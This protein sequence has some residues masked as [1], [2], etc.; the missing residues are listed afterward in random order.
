MLRIDQR[1]EGNTIVIRAEGGVAGPWVAEL[2]RA[3]APLNGS[4][5]DVALDLSAVGYVDSSGEQLLRE[6][7]SRGMRIRERSGFVTALFEADTATPSDR[8]LAWAILSGSEAAFLSL[9]SRCHEPM[10]AV[11][12]CFVASEATARKLVHQAW[13]EL[14]SSLKTW[15]GR[16]PLDSWAVCVAARRA[17]AHAVRGATEAVAARADE[18][19]PGVS[20]EHLHPRDQISAADDCFREPPDAWRTDR[21]EL[22]EALD[23]T[24]K[25][26]DA[27]PPMQRAVMTMRDVAGCGADETGSAL[28]I[29]QAE[30]RVLLHRARSSVHAAIDAH[31][32]TAA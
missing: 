31:F 7:V 18:A 8:E 15:N 20:P 24:R 28:N 29:S 27:L 21:L 4:A 11:T 3:L 23:A 2:G 22:P 10:L 19:G 25:A 6:A 12:R 30:Q 26:I 16:Q 14:L 13:S 5:T 17:R 32:R 1:R 9:A